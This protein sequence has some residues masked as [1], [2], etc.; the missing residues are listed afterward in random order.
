M[1]GGDRHDGDPDETVA[2]RGHEAPGQCGPAASTRPSPPWARLRPRRTCAYGKAGRVV[3]FGCRHRSDSGQRWRSV[4]R[5][6]E[7]DRV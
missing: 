5:N 2:D 4:L 3:R 1:E 7:L 6:R